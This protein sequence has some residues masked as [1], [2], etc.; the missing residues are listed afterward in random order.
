MIG[1]K[2]KQL[3]NIGYQ[4]FVTLTFDC[5]TPK[6]IGHIHDSWR[7]SICYVTRE[8][9][10]GTETFYLTWHLQT[11]EGQT[12]RWVIQVYPP[13]PL[14]LMQGVLLYYLISACNSDSDWLTWKGNTSRHQIQSMSLWTATPLATLKSNW[15]LDIHNAF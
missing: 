1:V 11:A 10:Y 15:S 3:C 7:V 9:R 2:E 4:W 8:S 14:A 6:S 12:D 5:W 13:I